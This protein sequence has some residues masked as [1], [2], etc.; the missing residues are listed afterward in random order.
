MAPGRRTPES[1]RCRGF[2]PNRPILSP[3]HLASSLRASLLDAYADIDTDAEG[4]R[5]RIHASVAVVLRGAPDPELL[6]IR[7]AERDSD[8]WSGQMALPGGRRDP[9]DRSL[10]DT[11]VRETEEETTVALDQ[12]GVPIGRLEGL[13]P[14][15]RRLPAI[16][17]FPFVFQVP[18]GT[19]AAPG[20]YEV[21]E[22]LWVPLSVL[23][24][25]E[26][27]GSVEIPVGDGKTRLFPCWRVEGRVV[28]GLTYRIL[29]RFLRRFNDSSAT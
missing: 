26:T 28:W 6:L 27:A 12:S 3:D 19:E 2:M 1:P 24:D 11:A 4:G 22:T 25:P 5:G 21:D 16:T 17:I 29:S 23:Q 10:F 20:S 15:T 14:A 8:P 13:E 7:R 9:T 18:D